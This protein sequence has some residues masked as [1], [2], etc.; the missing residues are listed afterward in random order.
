MTQPTQTQQFVF[1]PATRERCLAR[2]ALIGPS[3]SGKTR[4]ALEIAAALGQRIAVIDTEHGASRKFAGQ[5][6]AFDVLEL[7]TFSPLTYIKAI[8]SAAA[9]GYEVLIIDSLSHAWAGKGG[10][11]E[12]VDNITRRSRSNNAF[13]TGWRDVSPLHAQLVEALCACPM[14]LIVTMR[15]KMEYVLDEQ[16]VDG[17]KTTVP[18]KVGLAPIQ[19]DGLEYEFDVVGDLDLEHKWYV[20]KSRPDPFDGAVI[21]RPGRA[22]GEAYLSWLNTGDAPRPRLVVTSEQPDYE[23]RRPRHAGDRAR[24][25]EQQSVPAQG[26]ATAAEQPKPEGPC[27]SSRA[28][29]SGAK[30]WAGKPLASAPIEV[31]QTYHAVIGMALQDP[32]NRS[33]LRVLTDHRQNV[34]AAIAQKQR[35][36]AQPTAA[37]HTAGA[38]PLDEAGGWDDLPAGVDTD[39][40]AT[41]E[42]P[43]G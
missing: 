4:S 13:T 43:T 39:D 38:Q 5:V 12:Q 10:V 34:T 26:Q 24:R 33:R 32:K 16:V 2:I 21:E 30:E 42:Q 7:G 14:H 35:E 1:T 15:S 8:E 17:R 22:F 27:F 18:R 41:T 40:H 6:A 20:S 19:R 3:G 29:W 31:L 28:D 37:D 23:R 9:A 36:A 25:S 11:L